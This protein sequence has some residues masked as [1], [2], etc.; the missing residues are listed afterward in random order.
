[1]AD[2]GRRAEPGAARRPATAA[3]E[4][5]PPLEGLLAGLRLALG[6][7][8]A[9][10][11]RTSLFGVA[12]WPALAALA[13]HHRVGTL[14]LEGLGKGGVRPPDPAV[15]RAL[16]QQRRQDTLRGMRQLAAMER[17]TAALAAA[18]IRSLVL[19][20]L[21]LGQRI[22]GRPFAKSS[23]DIDLLVPEGAFSA[24]GR[25]L[26][27]LGWRLAM[28]DFR[29]TPARMRWYDSVQK[30]HVYT[31]TDS[32]IEL[33][34]RLLGNRFLFSP[35][36]TRLDAGALTVEVGRGRFRTLGDADQL[37]YLACHGTLH[38]WQRLKWLCDFAALLR[39][40]EDD[41]VE[42]AVARGR[43]GR[44]KNVLA[45]ALLLC[46][47]DL[48]VGTPEP[49]APLRRDCARVRFVAGLSRR[50][51]TP[52]EGFWHL[53]RKAAMR[54]GRVF[55]GSGVR[56]SLLEARGLLI[57]HH[58]FSRAELPDRLFWL[59]APLRPLLWALGV[60]AQAGMNAVNR[61]RGQASRRDEWVG[62]APSVPQAEHER[63]HQ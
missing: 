40:M 12:D 11:H 16:A 59:Y 18:G 5:T 7:G 54:A 41:S 53:V 49:A 23:I 60:R 50:S 2:A 20:G 9:A 47:D 4:V 55:I 33:H 22:Y 37:L 52:G 42:L 61:L 39:T 19:K 43:E 13:A 44:L 27:E 63:T 31:N 26:R 62:G 48:Q 35:P 8:N 32:K 14:F 17:V 51:W 28:P 24:A 6:A 10:E 58:D 30:E 36:F 57:R 3:G 38:Y 34:R 45:P 25:T 29:E 56:Y 46:R 15:E 1:M 21:P